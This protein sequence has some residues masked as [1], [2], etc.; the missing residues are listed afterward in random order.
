[1]THNDL[2]K[3]GGSGA[4][5]VILP[6]MLKHFTRVRLARCSL[7]NQALME[8]TRLSAQIVDSTVMVN[9]S[10]LTR[11]ESAGT[12]ARFTVHP[13]DKAELQQR[14]SEGDEMV[15]HRVFER[16]RVDIIKI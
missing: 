3:M 7:P 6:S 14:S 13:M 4:D 9:P 15:E 2:I 10:F 5:V 16:C 11:G 8:L 1:M 12:F